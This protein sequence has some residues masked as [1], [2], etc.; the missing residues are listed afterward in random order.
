MNEENLNS[1]NHPEND[2]KDDLFNNIDSNS[3][4]SNKP[5]TNSISLTT[6]LEPSPEGFISTEQLDAVF[7]NTPASVKK[8]IPAESQ[9]KA[10]TKTGTENSIDSKPKPIKLSA[11][12]DQDSLATKLEDSDTPKS[13]PGLKIEP[14]VKS[15]KIVGSISTE[16]ATVGQILQEARVCLELSLTQVE[17]QTKIKRSFLEA[18]ERD[19]LKNLPAMCY[20]SAYIK[21]LCQLYRID[22]ETSAALLAS[23]KEK[24]GE[25]AVPNELLQSLENEKHIN[26]EEEAKLKRYASYI[27]IS[28][29]FVGIVGIAYNM[30]PSE[31]K[32]FNKS[33]PQTNI[34]TLPA[35]DPKL[36]FKDKE[37]EVLMQNIFIDM[38]TLNIDDEP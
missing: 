30:W 10:P 36:H 33:T 34:E 1:N 31:N 15:I 20:V 23:L 19:D 12:P 9:L 28:I 25:R 18:V 4:D 5:S 37:L 21:T 16:N 3:T 24:K 27:I 7:G 6:M 35:N 8:D 22:N 29:I 11:K 2:S 32:S 14:G 13:K 38:S 17:Q 26:L